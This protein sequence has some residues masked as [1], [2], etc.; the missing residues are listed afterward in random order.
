MMHKHD[1]IHTDRLLCLC[2]IL[3]YM[4]K[5]LLVLL[6]DVPCNP[7]FFPIKRMGYY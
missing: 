4:D 3:Y 5:N 1:N 6:E 2:I 7:N